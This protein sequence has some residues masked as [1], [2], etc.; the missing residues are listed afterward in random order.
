MKREPKSYLLKEYGSW[1]VLIVSYIIGIGVSH[2]FTWHLFPLFGALALLINSKQAFMKW[3]RNKGEQIPLVV[4]L[5]HVIA[6]AAILLAVFRSDIVMLLPLLIFPAAY[7]LSNKLAG[8]HFLLTEIL[9][10]LL[11]S[12]AGVLSKFLLTGGL[13]VRLFIGLAMYFTA[14]VF[15]I[16]AILMKKTADRIMTVVS[17]LLSVY[18]YHRMFIPLLILLPLVENLVAA[19]TLYRVRLQTTGWIEVTKSILFLVLFLSYY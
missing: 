15:K 10:F 8:E 6:A 14:G 5:G 19:V 13:D 16:K 9:G 18:V 11:L 1:S 2:A 4:F 3:R 17:V 7:L 12:L